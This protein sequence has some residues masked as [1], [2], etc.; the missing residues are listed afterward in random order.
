MPNRQKL[1]ACPLS[2]GMGVYPLLPGSLSQSRKVDE[3][4]KGDSNKEG[5]KSDSFIFR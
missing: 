4:D 1:K 5:K 2:S 3:G